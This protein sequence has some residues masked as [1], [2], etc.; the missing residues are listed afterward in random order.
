MWL[1]GKS[2]CFVTHL[3][4]W[5]IIY[6]LLL[7]TV[8]LVNLDFKTPTYMFVNVYKLYCL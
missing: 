3:S 1:L 7:C 2:R 5:A 8:C 4:P 6:I